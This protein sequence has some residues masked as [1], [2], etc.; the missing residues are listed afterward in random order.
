MAYP[1]P[2]EALLP[3]EEFKKLKRQWVAVKDLIPTQYVVR[4]DRMQWLAAGNKPEGDDIPHC[5]TWYG[6]TYL[7]D[8]HHRWLLAKIQGVTTMVVRNCEIVFGA[9]NESSI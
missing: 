9:K 6:K 3:F 1:F 8:G 7:Y 2:E 5:V 4:I